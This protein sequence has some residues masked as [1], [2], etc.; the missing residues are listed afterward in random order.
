MVTPQ[1]PELWAPLSGGTTK[2]DDNGLWNM[3]FFDPLITAEIC[4]RKTTFKVRFPMSFKKQHNEE[5]IA[6][7]DRLFKDPLVEAKTEVEEFTRKRDLKMEM[8][9]K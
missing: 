5:R 7:I 2:L 4:E 1:K 9:E 6:L 3:K 8:K